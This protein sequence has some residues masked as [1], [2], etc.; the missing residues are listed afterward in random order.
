MPTQIKFY[1]KTYTESFCLSVCQTSKIFISVDEYAYS[2]A[3]LILM[4]FV[5]VRQNA[6]NVILVVAMYEKKSVALD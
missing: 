5:L 6:Y 2:N 3:Y 1:R 4:F